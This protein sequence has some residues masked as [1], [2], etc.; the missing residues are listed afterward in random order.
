M[1][2]I[3]GSVVVPAAVSILGMGYRGS[4][5]TFTLITAI[6]AN[7]L[8]SGAGSRIQNLSFDGSG[9]AAVTSIITLTGAGCQLIDLHIVQASA[10][11]QAVTAVTVGAVNCLIA[12]T[13]IDSTAAAGAAQAILGSAAVARLRV[14][15]CQIIGDFSAACMVCSSTNHLTDMLIKENTFVQRNG[16]AKAVF[17]F[18]TSS[19]GIVRDNA[20]N[21]TTWSTAADAITN[22]SST[23][24]RWF[25]NF[26]FDNGAGVVSGVLV[27][28]AGTIS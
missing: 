24:L 8:M 9:F 11:N 17:N 6:T 20:L 23:S 2:N 22:S 27:P 25:Q 1:E 26:G 13:L 18:T 4:R 10:T 3:S 28:A 12:D 14:L 19:T 21:G 15:N 16:T 5:G 7:I